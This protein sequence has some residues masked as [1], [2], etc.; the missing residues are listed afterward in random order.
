MASELIALPKPT[1]QVSEKLIERMDVFRMV[2]GSATDH[3]V[4]AASAIIAANDLPPG[5]TVPSVAKAILGAAY[6]QLPFGN[7]LGF[8]YL[9]PFKNGEASEKAG[10]KVCDVTL[11]IGYQG[12][13]EL[14]MRS[15]F[16]LSIY[17]EVVCDGEDFDFFVDETGQRMIHRPALDRIPSRANIKGAYCQY[18]L[19]NAPKPITRWI[20]RQEINQIDKKKDVWNSNFPAMCMKTAVRRAAKQWRKTPHLAYAVRVDEQS[21][22]DEVPDAPPVG[23]EGAFP[24]VDDRTK[25]TP[26]TE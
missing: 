21:D 25:W 13:Q 1:N 11:C 4:F 3:Q 10:H 20:P 2:L 9:L 14:G 22:R 16:L 12:F 26:P 24:E 7:H 6:L 19:P 17:P 8:A 15:G 5:C 23:I 18:T